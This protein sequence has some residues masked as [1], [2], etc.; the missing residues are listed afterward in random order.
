MCSLLPP[1]ILCFPG[2]RV[3]AQDC[4]PWGLSLHPSTPVPARLGGDPPP[5]LR[6]KENMGKQVPPLKK[7]RDTC[8]PFSNCKF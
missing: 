7:N 4:R 2:Q 1:P 3:G 8:L 5:L 6:F